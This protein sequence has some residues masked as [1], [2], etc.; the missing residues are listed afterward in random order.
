MFDPSSALDKLLH[1]L[2]LQVTSSR[3]LIESK[4]KSSS[5]TASTLHYFDK[6][7]SDKK[8]HEV[9]ILSDVISRLVNSLNVDSVIDLGSGKGY[10]SHVIAATHANLNVV[11]IEGSGENSE[12]ALK[13]KM[14]LEKLWDGLFRRAQIR[15]SGLQPPGRGK[16]WKSKYS[17]VESTQG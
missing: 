14:K 5:D 2:S 7:A 10:L 9:V 1:R 6:I 17:K 11:A 8:M 4:F 3:D 13:R 16:K 15:A 12:G